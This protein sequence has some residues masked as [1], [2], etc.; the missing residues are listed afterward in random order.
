MTTIHNVSRGDRLSSIAAR[1]N[2]TVEKLA[3]AN[4]IADPNKI[5]TGQKLVIPDGF[6]QPTTA[7]TPTTT[8]GDKFATPSS[9]AASGPVRDDDGRTFPT[10]RDGTPMYKQGDDQWGSRRLGTGSSV[11]AAGCAMTATAMAVSKI[12]G[13]TINPGEMDAY[14][15]KNGGYSGNALNWGTAAKMGGLSAAKSPWNLD[16]INKQIDAGRPVVVGVDYRAGSNGGANGTDHWI[17]ITGRGSENGKP[18]YY[19]NDPATGK[20]ITLR[21]DGNRLS[22]GP[23]GYKT[24]GE[25]V[26]FSGGNPKPGGRPPSDGGT[27]DGTTTKPPPDSKPKPGAVKGMALPGGD[28]EKGARGAEVEQLQKA[29]VKGGYM[30][31]AEMKTGPGIFGPRTEQALKEFQADNGVKNTGYYGPLTR[32]AFDKLGAKVGGGGAKVDGGDNKPGTTDGTTKPSTVKG[33]NDLSGFSS[34]KYD[35]LINEMSQKYKVP[36]RLIKA[37]I[38][39]ESAFNPNATSGVGAKGL[40][41]LMPATAKELGVT[42]RT[43][44]RQSIEGGTKYLAQ[45]LKTFKGDVTLA[46]AAYNAGAGNVNKYGGVP[47]FKETQNY[48]KKITGWY[49]GTGPA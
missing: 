41:Q 10:S 17:T 19:A 27:T 37:V 14:L 7:K 31:E 18:V 28:L 42:D 13:Q 40:M 38:Q 11:G 43:D 4:N 47:P 30:T 9:K 32:A 16:T 33:N 26:T 5:R 48:V 8:G 29:L 34:N 6:D 1:Y 35:N 36:A 22:G 39:Q 24:T 25:L 44:P 46:L 23:S 21:P 2:T 20:E 12:T 45:Q 3:Q 15:D 49:N